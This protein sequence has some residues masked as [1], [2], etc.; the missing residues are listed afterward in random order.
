M[1]D[2]NA[3]IISQYANSP[4]I[5]A[6]ISNANAYIDPT[7]D[8][9]NFYNLVW[10]IN[11]AVGFGLD[12]WGRI[13][14]ITRLLEI[15]DPGP[16]F[17]FDGSGLQPFGQGTFGTHPANTSYLLTDDAYRVLLLLKAMVN[18]SASD[19]PTLNGILASLMAGRGRCYILE[20]ATMKIRYV[21]EFLL[22][23]YER[24]LFS[25]PGITPHPAGVEY[26]TY[27]IDAPGT[28]GFDGSGLQPFGQGTFDNGGIIDVN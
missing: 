1:Q 18:I 4:R 21:F 16:T 5:V 19:I 6:L 8:F 10:N 11:T 22:M 15:N 17:G 14:G 7:P 9:D 23:P 26:Q 28:F 27:E 25:K 20:V 13:L 12:I 24:A 3:T 2:V